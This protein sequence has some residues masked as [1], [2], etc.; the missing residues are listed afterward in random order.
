M[1]LL[2]G[3]QVWLSKP[4]GH[5]SFMGPFTFQPSFSRNGLGEEIVFFCFFGFFFG[6][7]D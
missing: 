6:T 1:L 2:E 5:L 4:V 3:T 7:R